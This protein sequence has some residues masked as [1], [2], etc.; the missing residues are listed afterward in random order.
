MKNIIRSLLLTVLV[1]G[2]FAA[3]SDFDEININPTAASEDQV[4]VEYFINNSI[5]GAQQDPHIAERAFVLYWKAAGRM[6]RTNTLPVGAYD[7]GWTSDYFRYVSGWLNNADTAVEIADKRIANG[8]LKEYTNNLKQVARIWRVYLLSEM[9][10]NFGPLPINGFQ[11]VNPDFNSLQEVYTFLLTE[12]Q[13]A[14]AEMD[15]TITPPNTIQNNDPA[16]G[17]NFAKWVKYGNSMRMRLAMRVSEADPAMARE[18]FEAAANTNEFI[19]SLDDNFQVQETGGWDPL[20]GVMT[21]EWNMQYLSPTMNNLMIGLGGIESEDQLPASYGQYVKPGNYLGERYEDHFT[22]ETNDP[23][24][25]YW[26]D[27][28]HETID[29]RSYVQFI[30][31]GDFDNP[32][33]NRYPTYDLPLTGDTKRTLVTE[34]GNTVV[35]EIEAAF[36]WNAPSIGSWGAKG[37]KNNVYSHAGAVPRLA[38][39]FRDGSS[40]RIFFPSWES[41]FLI[42]EA[43]VRG[44][45]TPMSG[46]E[47]YE[48][49]IRESFEYWGVSD[50]VEEY[51][52][53]EDYNRVGTSVSWNHT[54]EP[55]ATVTMEYVNGYT[56]ETGTVEFSYP[57]NHLY[58]NGTVKN[59]ALTKILT[60]KFI[61]QS[62]WLPLETWNDHRRLGLPFFENPAVENALPNMPQLNDNNYTESRWE[63]FPQRLKYPANLESN[64]PD[65]YSQALQHLGGPDD[66][67]TPLW[68]TGR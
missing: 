68:W 25:G 60:Q 27:G 47:A 15:L 20:T 61:A 41:Y 16:Y 53:S 55:P 34:D 56:G 66:V 59:D 48:A 37:A 13:E 10:D 22:T 11:G 64:V 31:P 24:A 65:G 28:L 43:A 26:F 44:W 30:I 18:H 38:N 67:F 21:R 51:L 62:P 3:C 50:F 29:P 1:F 46:Q 54:T 40:Q 6:D 9:A 63:F 35:K 5:V 57:D 52:T 58:M 36:T 14:V 49:G 23:S 39:R 7:D 42:A 33:M 45:N 12:L 4:Q 17:Y 32:E 2:F 19:S 8:H